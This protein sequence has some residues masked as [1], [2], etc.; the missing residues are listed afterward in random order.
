[1]VICVLKI[2]YTLHGNQL[3]EFD[4]YNV[5]GISGVARVSAARGGS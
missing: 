1:M 2:K 3:I 4:L 5:H